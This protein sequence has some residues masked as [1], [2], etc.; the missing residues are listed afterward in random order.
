MAAGN[1]QK[2]AEHFAKNPFTG[3]TSMQ[4]TQRVAGAPEQHRYDKQLDAALWPQGGVAAP[5]KK[6]P[7]SIVFRHDGTARE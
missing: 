6:A 3:E 2:V 4:A 7:M 1:G 5:E